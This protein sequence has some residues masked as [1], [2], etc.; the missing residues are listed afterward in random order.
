MPIP[1][2]DTTLAEWQAVFKSIR[3]KY[4]SGDMPYIAP[5]GTV[6]ADPGTAG[7]PLRKACPVDDENN[8]F[9]DA[10][11]RTWRPIPEIM[12]LLTWLRELP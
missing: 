2:P 11:A 7:P 8:L 1:I 10:E 4:R 5:E 6:E 3:D 9:Y 12:E